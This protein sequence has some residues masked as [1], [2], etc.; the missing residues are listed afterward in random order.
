LKQKGGDAMGDQLHPN[1]L[2]LSSGKHGKEGNPNCSRLAK[3]NVVTTSG[4]HSL[5]SNE[6]CG[7]SSLLDRFRLGGGC[8]CGGWDMGCPLTIFGNPNIQIAENQQ[9]LELFI[10]GAKEYTPALTMKVIEEGRYS[11]DFHAK[12]SSLQAFS[13]CVAMLHCT[14]ASAAVR[15]ERDKQSL[16][17]NPLRVF[18]EEEV[19]NLID[20]VA[21]EEERKVIKKVKEIPPSFKLNPP[22]SPIARV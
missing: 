9:P 1:L 3:V 11:V 8:E 16:H 18:I 20:A 19:K 21:E 12:L 7:P 15:W 4:N 14:E 5:G 13:I 6:S 10:Q 2:D 22:F 17:C